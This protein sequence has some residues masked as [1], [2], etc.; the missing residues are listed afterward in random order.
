MRNLPATWAIAAMMMLQL[1]VGLAWQ[2]VHA[3]SALAEHPISGMETSQCPGHQSTDSRDHPA[4]KH[5]CCLSLGCQ[6]HSAQSLGALIPP[7]THAAFSSLHLLPSF[8]ARPP[9][10]RT[11]EFFRP[12]IA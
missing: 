5:D 9:V 12:P 8:D 1:A 2:T 11:T 4:K 6:C 10:A 7:P 3:A